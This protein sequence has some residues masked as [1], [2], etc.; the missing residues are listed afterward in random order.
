MTDQPKRGRGRPKGPAATPPLPQRKPYM[1]YLSAAE[2]A[3][4]AAAA[5]TTGRSRAVFVREAALDKA[6]ATRPA[7]GE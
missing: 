4:I 3:E 1:I 7:E 5:H 2:E 6:R